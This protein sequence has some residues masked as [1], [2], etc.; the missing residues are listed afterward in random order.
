MIS[1]DIFAAKLSV[2]VQRIHGSRTYDRALEILYIESLK[3]IHNYLALCNH[4]IALMSRRLPSL[5][6]HQKYFITGGDLFFLVRV[7]VLVTKI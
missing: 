2:N 7:I 4:P 1:F 3:K 5:H 6:E